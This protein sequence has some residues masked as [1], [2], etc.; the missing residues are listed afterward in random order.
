MEKVRGLRAYWLRFHCTL[1]HHIILA[2]VIAVLGCCAVVLLCFLLLLLLLLTQI[3]HVGV[4]ESESCELVRYV[5][6]S[7]AAF[8]LAGGLVSGREA[9]R[10]TREHVEGQPRSSGPRAKETEC[11]RAHVMMEIRSCSP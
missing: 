4:P 1:V 2:C 7:Y 8:H 3:D 5:H 9:V 11:A 10:G 6:V